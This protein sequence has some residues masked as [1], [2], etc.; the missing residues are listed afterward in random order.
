MKIEF[1]SS[2]L[3]VYR[4]LRDYLIELKL[5]IKSVINDNVLKK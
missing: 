3:N 4:E 1:E 2:N 5:P